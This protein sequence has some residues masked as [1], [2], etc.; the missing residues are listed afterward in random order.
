[1]FKGAQL[2]GLVCITLLVCKPANTQNLQNRGSETIT[3][4]PSAPS[5]PFPH[6]WE[7]MFGSGRAILSLRDDYRRDLRSVHAITGFEYVRFHAIFHDEA[8]LY[9]EDKAGNVSWNFS[10]VDQ[11]YDGLLANGVRPFVE[12]S[13]MPNQLA[14]GPPADFFWYK[15]NP[16]PPKDNAKW[17]RMIDAFVRHLLARYGNAEVEQWYFEVWNEPNLPF[18]TGMP[19][20]DTYYA[21]YDLTVKTLRRADPKLRVGGPATAQAVWVDRF[22]AHCL[23][24]GVPFDFVSTH[25]YGNESPKDVFGTEAPVDIRNMVARALT[26]VHDQVVHSSAPATPVIISEFNA[27]YLNRVDIEDSA[28]MGPWLANTIR[29]CDGLTFMMSYWTFSDVF[30]E[31]GVVKTPFYGGFGLVAERGI[32][33]AAFRAL[34]L[35]H[36]LGDTRLASD[37][38]DAIITKRS[39]GTVAVA[40]WNYAEPDQAGTTKTIQLRMKNGAKGKYSIRTVAPGKGSAVEE[41]IRMGK[42]DFPTREQIARLIASSQLTP[43]A[44]HSLSVPVE[45]APH[46]LA[47]VELKR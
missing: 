20:E 34:E 35:L 42:P 47:L 3:I 8:G 45:L 11:I 4:D 6:F 1:M 13:F 5:H 38:D 31:Q 37:S 17:A 12:L 15:L 21:L 40:L 19:A 30:E 24:A 14:T 7:R 36:Q 25:I 10:Y 32:P 44:E 2:T 33:K 9:N 29:A 46:E 18:W 23:K 28:F 39:D 27:A 41:W 22:I 16:S 26:K 43:A